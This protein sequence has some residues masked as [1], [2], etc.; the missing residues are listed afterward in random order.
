[1]RQAVT[2]TGAALVFVAVVASA[3]TPDPDP[4]PDPDR[5]RAAFEKRCTGCHGLDHPKEGPALRGIYGR[6]AGSVKGFPYSDALKK[7][8][9]KWDEMTLDRWVADP[10]AVAPGNE[11]AFRLEDNG[12]RRDI[13]A[14]LK[15]LGR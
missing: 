7:A 5:G 9:W 4:S 6:K 11:M 15:V 2:I 14:Y 3:P 12:E 1:M 13:V 10:E 8:D